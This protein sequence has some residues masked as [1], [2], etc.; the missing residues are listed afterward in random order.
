M[1]GKRF[2]TASQ[3][4]TENYDFYS[5][6]PGYPSRKAITKVTKTA[7]MRSPK[8]YRRAVDGAIIHGCGLLPALDRPFWM[9][10]WIDG[11]M[12]NASSSRQEKRSV[13]PLISMSSWQ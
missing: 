8:L 3:R 7:Q 10:C 9:R 4:T 11:K 1:I 2:S 6:V 13:L 5:T 12:Q